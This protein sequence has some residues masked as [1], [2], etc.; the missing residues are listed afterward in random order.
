VEVLDCSPAVHVSLTQLRLLEPAVLLEGDLTGVI[1]WVDICRADVGQDLQL[2]WSFLP[3]SARDE[4]LDAI[5]GHDNRADAVE[6]EA[7]S[8]LERTLA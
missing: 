6:A 7:I 8:A 1:D 3:P 2:L 5:Y 4:F